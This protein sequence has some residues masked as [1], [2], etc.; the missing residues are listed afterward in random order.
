MNPIKKKH[1]VGIIGAGVG[2]L[3]SAARLAHRGHPVTVYEKLPECGGRAH[4]IEDK[5]FRFDTGPSFILMPDF[6]DE[7]FSD[8]GETLS[9][10]LDLRYLPVSYKIFYPD[11][12]TFTVF[13]DSG[14][15]ADECARLEPGGDDA[16][17]GFIAHAGRI[18]D[19]VRPLLTTC[20][21]KKMLLNPSYLS[22]LPRID[23][24]RSF[25]ACA[26]RFFKSDRLAYAF[27]F[28][29][30]FMGVSPFQAPAFYSVITY[31]DHTQKIAHPMGGMYMLPKALERLAQEKGVK[32][33][34]DDEVTSITQKSDGLSLVTTSGAHTFDR[35]I[36]NADLPHTKRD[37]CG[38]PLPRYT[39][40]CSVF[41]VYLGMKKKIPGLEHHNLFFAR[42]LDKNMKEIF[43]MNVTP[44][45][46]SFYVHVP[47]VTDPSLAPPEKDILYI[48]I[49]V[50]N[51][52]K[53]PE[54]I[55]QHDER[56]RALVIDRI[57]RLTG[58]NIE[59]LIEVE[60]RFYPEDFIGRYN[61]LYGATFG[62]AHNLMQ[63]AFFR[64]PNYEPSLKG[65]FYAGASA[66]PGGG[67]PVVLASSKI[68]A[69]LVE[70]S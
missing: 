8:C 1:R 27:T 4:C 12:E 22:L 67:L 15:T 6:F 25:W 3:A 50:A 60:H 19:A 66:Q 43:T 23:P 36:A 59:A 34:Y 38:L 16:F 68:A 14:R 29:S 39:Y 2:G 31:S 69:D 42:D 54:D 28:E 55:H 63:S 20:L 51:L 17:R 30:M 64:P 13:H 32:I 44:A 58:E 62:L 70:K 21:T 56:L 26:K 33:A 37:L 53:S 9:S 57:S 24:F 18:Y 65:L 35:V 61:I 7:V 47:T 49:P 52:T 46:P 5:G 11:G 41:L 48:L 45:D 10:Y 40:S